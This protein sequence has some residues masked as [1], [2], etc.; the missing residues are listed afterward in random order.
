MKSRASSHLE[1]T[2][3]VKG[4]VIPKEVIDVPT[5]RICTVL[6]FKTEKSKICFFSFSTDVLSFVF[7]RF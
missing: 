5:I 4:T 7:D 1:L 2:I 3:N 6:D